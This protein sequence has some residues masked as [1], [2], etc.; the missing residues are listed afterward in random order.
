M[1]VTFCDYGVTILSYVI[2]SVPVFLGKFDHISGGELSSL[3]SRSDRKSV[4]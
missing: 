1:F 2:V 3:I 4:V